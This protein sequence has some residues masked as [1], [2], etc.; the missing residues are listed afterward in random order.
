MD[1]RGKE[2]NDG[3][4][5]VVRK[6]EILGDKDIEAWLSECRTKST[7]QIY[8]Y[9]AN[10]F[11]TWL[12]KEKGLGLK[13][14]TDEKGIVVWNLEFKALSMKEMKTMLLQ[15]QNSKPLSMGHQFKR[16]YL[17][18]KPLS[19][20]AISDVITAIQ[21]FCMYLEKPL[22]LKGKTLNREDDTHSHYFEETSDLTKMY[23]ICDLKGKAILATAASLG[24]GRADVL[25][26]KRDFIEAHLKKAQVE[27]KEYVYFES[28]RIKT[29]VPCLGVLNPLAIKSLREWLAVS[30]ESTLFYE[31]RSSIT[32]FMLSTAKKANLVTTGNVKFHRI[33]AWTFNTLLRA[34]F[35]ELAAKYIVGKAIPH[36]DSTYVRL[37]KDIEEKYPKLYGEYLDISGSHVEKLTNEDKEALALMKDPLFRRFIKYEMEKLREH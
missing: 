19:I 37:R 24:W 22:R 34:G 20:N 29:G 6:T 23:E 12:Q 27:G 21:S 5:W 10:L 4:P 13:Q 36:S 8:T 9:G 7:R 15:Y 18:P 30:H 1:R 35:N 17:P 31:Y 26:L 3:I 2:A 11:F 25:A 28:K 16:K 32:K 33:R 14:S